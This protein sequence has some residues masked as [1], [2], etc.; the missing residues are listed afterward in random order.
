MSRLI[1]KAFASVALACLFVTPSV[2]ADT[3]WNVSL[4]GSSRAVTVSIEHLAKEIERRTDGALRMVIHFGEAISPARENID[5]IA[6]GAFEAGHICPSY[7]PGKTPALLAMEL[8]F[9]PLNDI[10]VAH[11]VALKTHTHPV[12]ERELKKFN[13]RVMQHVIA[14]RY[15]FM[16]RGAPPKVLTAWKGMRVRAPGAIGEGVRALGGRPTSV[17][18]PE[19][20]T[21]LERRLFDAA[22]LPF[23]YPFASYRIHEVAEW[24]TFNMNLAFPS[25]VVLVSQDAWAALSDNERA[26]IDEINIEAHEL[27]FEALADADTA[28]IPE[29]DAAGLERIVYDETAI[30]EFKSKTSR[31]LWDEWVKRNSRRFPAEDYLN[32]ILAEAAIANAEME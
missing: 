26:L 24:Y 17:P 14:P 29:F 27:Q 19:I 32:F 8:P 20:Y 7:H 4:W 16:G 18:A 13:A 3:V 9:L 1:A 25:C 23:S 11:K 15:E 22:A 10:R 28:W 2:S 12:I 31:P 21:S 30:E 5:G 6:L